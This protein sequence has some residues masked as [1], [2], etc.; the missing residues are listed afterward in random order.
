MNDT[1]I[2]IKR[3]RREGGGEGGGGGGGE[4]GD[5]LN[6][7]LNDFVFLSESSARANVIQIASGRNT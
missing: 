6:E 4:G 3:W 1:N 7:S 2:S 5:I